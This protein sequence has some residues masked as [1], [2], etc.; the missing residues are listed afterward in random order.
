MG[1][2][3]SCTT[4]RSASATAYTPSKLAVESMHKKEQAR[5]VAEAVM[6]RTAGQRFM[7]NYTRPVLVSFGA[8][9]KV[10][11]AYS[12]GT[13]Q[14]VAVKMIPKVR[15]RHALDARVVADGCMQCKLNPATQ[16]ANVLNEVG[17]LHEV[18]DHPNAVKLIEVYEDD[19]TFCLVMDCCDG[20]EL[21]EHLTK[22]KA[23]MHACMQ[24]QMLACIPQACRYAGA[25][26]ICIASSQE[27]FTERQAAQILRSIM[28]FLAHMHSKGMA[29]MDIKPENM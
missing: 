24:N 19:Q 17:I 22:S 3:L 6:H 20:G 23:R 11:T 13:Q 1:A 4:T 12:R 29:H 25:E 16:R 5:A 14:K 15:A 28:L 21:F 27:A 7:D 18:E 10:L 9:C 2:H 8:N 26:N